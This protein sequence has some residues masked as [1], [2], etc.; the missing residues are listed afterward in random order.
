MDGYAK[1]IDVDNFIDYYILHNLSR[2]SDGL[3][4]SMWIYNPDPNNGGKLKFGPPW[5]HDLG[6]FEGNPTSSTLHRADRLWYDRL[7]DDPAF[8]S[9]YENRWHNW[10]QGILS[11]AGMNQVFD[12]F[13]AEIDSQAI[14][15][16][17]VQ[18]L[19]N[20]IDTVKSWLSRRAEAIDEAN[21]GVVT[22]AFT[23]DETVGSPPL[24]VQFRDQSAVPGA[25]AWFWEFGDGQTSHDRNPTHTYTTGGFFDVSLTVTGSIG[26]VTFSQ[27]GYIAA[28]L[29]GDV[30]LD[31][32]LNFGDVQQF[33]DHWRATTVQLTESEKIMHGDLNRDGETNLA[34]WHILRV[35][36][37]SQG[38]RPLDLGALLSGNPTGKQIDRITLTYAVDTNDS[39]STP[40]MVSNWR[41]SAETALAEQTE[42]TQVL[43]D[44]LGRKMLAEER[45]ARTERS[46]AVSKVDQI[47]SMSLDDLHFS[48]RE[49]DD[50]PSTDHWSV[51]LVL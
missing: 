45:R 29:P 25:R 36:W 17:G 20:R 22:V 6:S 16:D 26:D 35:A 37:N 42:L 15:R 40:A 41:F 3:L 2:N 8:V 13:V 4:L 39:P 47:W 10:R 46:M 19:N 32:Q 43:S 23:S 48:D 49:F 5:D 50:I 30:N 18:G 1:Y 34:D 14:A 9:R 44:R 24:T 27:P 28:I 7:F 33:I 12:D 31:G 11:D 51:A 21:G 38:F